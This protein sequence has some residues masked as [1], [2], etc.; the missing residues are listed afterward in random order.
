MI[1][2]LLDNDLYKFTMQQ[3]VCLLYPNAQAEY[4]LTNRGGTPFPQGFAPKV[5]TEIQRMAGLTL[6]LEQKRWLADTC[7]FFSSQY[8]TFLSDFRFDPDQVQ[9]KQEGTALRLKVKG[10]WADTILWEVP[11]MAVISELY[12]T[13]TAP[14]PM[15]RGQIRDRNMEKAK[16]L[17]ENGVS[18]VDFGTRR[19]YSADNHR[20]LI[21]DMLDVPDH[22]LAGTSNVHL[23]REFGIPPVGT[24]AHEWIMFHSAMDKSIQA[25]ALAMDAWTQVYPDALGIA[26]SDTYT[27]DTFLAVFDEKRARQ[28][29]GVRQDSGDPMRFTEKIMAHYKKLNIDPMEK[30]IVFSDGLD[31]NDAL[32]I[33][34]F[35]HGKIR[36]A[37]GIGTSLTNDVGVTPLNIVIKLRRCKTGR[38][39]TWQPTVKL[40]DDPGKHTGHPAAIQQCLSEIY[41]AQ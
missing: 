18:F 37:Y 32:A 26:L 21:A 29:I 41:G 2:S 31:V 35:C 12:F 9:L 6:D 25:N 15:T 33:H 22:T 13:M 38:D 17:A 8:L 34:N 20:H 40:S 1:Q 30:T 19:R 16:I 3:A 7:P 27:T 10:R 36:D 24:L 14:A 23:A 4:E 5:Q 11:L 39:D 28:F